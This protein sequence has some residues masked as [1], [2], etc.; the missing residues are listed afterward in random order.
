MKEFLKFK[1]VGGG[2]LEVAI[3]GT[4]YIPIDNILMT[5]GSGFQV[6]MW[7]NTPSSMPNGKARYYDIQLSDNSLTEET[8]IAFN[9]ALAANPGG[10]SI[11]VQLPAGQTITSW[12]FTFFSINP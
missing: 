10:K 11:E 12:N 8:V 1:S 9:Q 7:Q 3:P 5:V 4:Y 6:T 2:T